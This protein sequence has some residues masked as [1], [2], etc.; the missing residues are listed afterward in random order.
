MPDDAR[1]SRLRER[2]AVLEANHTT[3]FKKLDDIVDQLKE[4]TTFYSRSQGFAKGIQWLAGG[5]LLVVGWGI[6]HLSRLFHA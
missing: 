3:L 4:L 6:E 5:L 2:V 1:D